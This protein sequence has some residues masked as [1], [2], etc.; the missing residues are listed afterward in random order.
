MGKLC[1]RRSICGVFFSSSSMWHG[2]F[3]ILKKTTLIDCRKANS[4][5]FELITHECRLDN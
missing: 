1:N 4:Q 5:S 2:N 3:W